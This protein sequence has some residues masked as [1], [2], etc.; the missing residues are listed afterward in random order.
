[1]ARAL[2][3]L[4]GYTFRLAKSGS[5][6]GRDA[7]TPKAPLA[8]AMEAKR[9]TDSVPPEAVVGRAGVAAFAI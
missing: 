4:S 9:Y 8:I 7:A 1:V 5:Q 3:A 2:A 6:F